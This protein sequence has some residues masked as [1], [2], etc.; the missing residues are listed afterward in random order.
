MIEI[1]CPNACVNSIFDINLRSLRAR[2]IKGI[3][4]DLDNTL[5]EWDNEELPEEVRE[6]V[7][8]ARKMGFRICIASNGLK[9]RVE[10]F[11]R[12]LKIP[13]ISKAV[14]P[15]KRPF[16]EAL[17]ILRTSPAQTVVVGDQIFTDI[18]GGNRLELYTILISPMSDREA[19]TT[20]VVRKV[21]N[22][23]VSRLQKKGLIP[24]EVARGK[25]V[26]A[27]R[28]RRLIKRAWSWA[29]EDAKSDLMAG[30][31]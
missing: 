14:K 6:W 13:A 28:L 8:N 9:D 19:V 3:I 23:V 25:R 27:R 20:R 17:R 22:G 10:S 31:R 2:G 16:L 11:A 18:W 30:R 29:S 1:F 24:E 15:S 12:Q 21:E 4:I 5:V 7:R 26:K